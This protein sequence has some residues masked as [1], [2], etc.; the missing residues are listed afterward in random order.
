MKTVFFVF[1][2]CLLN[3]TCKKDDSDFQVVTFSDSIVDSLTKKGIPNVRVKMLWFS[4]SDG[5]ETIIDS[6]LTNAE[7]KY[8]FSLN[9]DNSRFKHELLNTIAVIPNNYVSPIGLEHSTVGISTSGIY[10]N[11]MSLITLYLLP[12]AHLTINLNRTMNDQFD[13]FYLYY[14]YGGRQ[15][16]PVGGY[17]STAQTYNVVTAAGV[18]TTF[19]WLKKLSGNTTS[20]SQDSII[21]FPNSVNQVTMNY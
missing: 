8:T 16:W 1:S 4:T 18:K 21:C 2:L 17:L 10:S 13:Q 20:E 7:G 14:D 9:I 3:L 11:N 12:K 6:T 5:K 15:Y 19:R